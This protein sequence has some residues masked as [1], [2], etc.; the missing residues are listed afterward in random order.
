M[1]EVI[2]QKAETNDQKI[3]NIQMLENKLIKQQTFRK[4]Y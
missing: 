3:N 4:T 1:S 2:I